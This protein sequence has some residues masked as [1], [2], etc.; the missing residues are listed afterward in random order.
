MRDKFAQ[1]QDELLKWI[2]NFNTGLH[3]ENWRILDK[4]PEPKGQR[5]I[6]HI[7]QDSFLAIKRTGF[8]IFTGLSQGTV[9]ILK[10]LKAQHQKEERA[11]LNIASSESVSEGEG[12]GTPTPSDDQR[13]AAEAK[14]EIP[15]GFKS[16]SA[17]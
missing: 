16:T 17:D 3:T 9:K 10:D 7:D 11:V 6:L 14:E 5:L 13:G 15:L 4:Q 12:N 8:K 1:T 2:K